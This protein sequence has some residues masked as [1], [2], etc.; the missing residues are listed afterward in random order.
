MNAKEIAEQAAREVGAGLMARQAAQAQELAAK[1]AQEAWSETVAEFRQRV[2]DFDAVALNPNLS[3]TPV[4]ADAIR[5]SGRGGEIAYYLSKNPA[6]A[7]R[8]A[9]LP[10]VSQATAIARL[11]EVVRANKPS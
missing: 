6:E 1:A 9:V 3:I 2:P 8:I 10:P 5:E 4:M 11:G 7:A